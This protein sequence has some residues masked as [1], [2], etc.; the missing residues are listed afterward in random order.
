MLVYLREETLVIE[1]VYYKKDSGEH[2]NDDDDTYRGIGVVVI[3]LMSGISYFCCLNIK[4]LVLKE[5]I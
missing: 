1:D 5:L 4:I 2:K 3:V